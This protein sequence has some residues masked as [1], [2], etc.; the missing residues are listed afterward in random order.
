MESKKEPSD[1]LLTHVHTLEDVRRI[2]MSGNGLVAFT[3]RCGI[4]RAEYGV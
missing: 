1:F 4:G 3:E 2:Y